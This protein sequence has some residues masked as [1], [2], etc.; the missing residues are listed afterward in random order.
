M[1]RAHQ[2]VVHRVGEMVGGDAVGFQQD[3]INVVF[4]D[5]Q[6]ALDQIVVLEL[7]F[8][9]AGGAEAQHPRLARG[10]GGLYILDGTVA[11]DGVAAVVAEVDLLLL[12]LGAH[13]GQL[14]LRAEAGVGVAL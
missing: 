7:V 10:D 11:P 8:N 5:G 9:G 14:L 6:R 1:R 2:V 12:L 13:G 4:R 3:L